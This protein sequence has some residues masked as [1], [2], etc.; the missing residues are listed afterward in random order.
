MVAL[1]RLSLNDLQLS[2]QV[3]AAA[4]SP[5]LCDD[6]LMRLSVSPDGVSDINSLSHPNI[7]AYQHAP[8]AHFSAR[9][10]H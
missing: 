6:G 9:K 8:D 5:P 3:V 1:P 4:S 7:A 2:W 10:R